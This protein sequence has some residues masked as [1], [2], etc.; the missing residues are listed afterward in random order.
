MTAAASMIALLLCSLT[1]GVLFAFAVV[2]MPGLRTLDDAAYLR[3]F[4]LMDGVIQNNQPLFMLVWV[5]SVVAMLA[6]LVLGVG[7]LTGMDRMLLLAAAALYLGGV[8]LTTII[9]HLPLNS[10]VQKLNLDVFD[11]RALQK[12]R[13]AFETRWNR[14]NLIRTGFAV[15][16]VVL[17]LILLMRL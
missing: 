17:M 9:I 15:G 11:S 6:A 4:Q 3:A 14:W 13:T 8:Q 12:A 1:A 7:T 10:D 5:G 16:A 2:V